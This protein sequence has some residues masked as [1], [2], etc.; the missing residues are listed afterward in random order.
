[1]IYQ[2]EQVWSGLGGQEAGM[3]VVPLES[4]RS[5]DIAGNSLTDVLYGAF[6]PRSVFFPQT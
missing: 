2:S 3:I 4:Q 1:M 5:N 6:N